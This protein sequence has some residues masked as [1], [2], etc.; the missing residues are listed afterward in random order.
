MA[1]LFLGFKRLARKSFIFLTTTTTKTLTI[2]RTRVQILACIRSDHYGMEDV[3]RN[4][5]SPPTGAESFGRVQFIPYDFMRASATHSTDLM[6]RA[7]CLPVQTASA[8]PDADD[9]LV[10]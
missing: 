1:A 10:T 7:G 2:A 6:C 5:A 9:V 4:Y 8:R 3:V